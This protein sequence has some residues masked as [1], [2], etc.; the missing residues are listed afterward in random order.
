MKRNLRAKP[1]V[2]APSLMVSDQTSFD[3]VGLTGRQLR[4]FLTA[5]PEIP[6][7]R[8]GQRVLVRADILVASLDKLATGHEPTGGADFHDPD[9]LSVDVILASVRRKVG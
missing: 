4:D 7:T 6:R 8:V 9:D 2:S 1:V 5:H 3:I